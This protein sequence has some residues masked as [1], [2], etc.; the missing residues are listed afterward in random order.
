MQA[1][2][3]LVIRESSQRA[4]R[5]GSAVWYVVE[6]LRR[7]MALETLLLFRFG[8]ELTT[9]EIPDLAGG[10]DIPNNPFDLAAIAIQRE[11]KQVGR[12]KPSR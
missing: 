5:D 6:G 7:E 8:D 9:I 11:R 2:I 12:F 1:G 3:V 10:G 4:Q